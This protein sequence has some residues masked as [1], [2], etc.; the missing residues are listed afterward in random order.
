MDFPGGIDH[1]HQFE[2]TGDEGFDDRFNWDT[3]ILVV[4]DAISDACARRLESI[5][6]YPKRVKLII[7]DPPRIFDEFMERFGKRFIQVETLYINAE[8]DEYITRLLSI[9]PG[10]RQLGI[11][12]G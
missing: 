1:W 4:E 10:L 6:T 3:D 9:M 2:Y 5:A 12:T 7:G 11:R 8:H